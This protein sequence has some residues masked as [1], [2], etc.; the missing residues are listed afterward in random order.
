VGTRRPGRP[1]TAYPV[2]ETYVYQSASCPCKGFS[3]G[4]RTI[5]N[6]C[7]R[8]G[9]GRLYHTVS[10]WVCVDVQIGASESDEKKGARGSDGESGEMGLAPK[11]WLR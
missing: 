4:H 3:C 5:I 10:K 8:P 6:T 2:F 9:G 7:E 1:R 11:G